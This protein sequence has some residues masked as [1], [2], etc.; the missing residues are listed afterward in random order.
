MSES[1]SGLTHVRADGSAHMVDVS[2][3]PET[4]REATAEALLR[5][6]PDV[7]ALL[8]DGNLPK[9]DALAVARVAGIMGAKKTPELVPL[10]H[11][12]P[13]SKVVVDFEPDQ[14]AGTVRILATVKTRGVTGVEMEA[15][16]A[17]SVAALTL[18]DMLKAVDKHAVV[19]GLRVL[20]TSGGKSG[21]WSLEAG[22][23]VPAG[24]EPAPRGGGA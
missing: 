15:L 14:A 20:A 8:A 19:D 3:K 7:V 23:D 10:C 17:A 13:L 2:A 9:G 1:P 21:D 22:G 24:G 4:S 5:T 6:R 11:P 12:L 18:Y 16:T